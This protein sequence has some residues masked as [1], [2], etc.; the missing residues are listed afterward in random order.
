MITYTFEAR[1]DMSCEFYLYHVRVN[2]LNQAIR[3]AKEFLDLGYQ[4]I[5]V[6]TR[7]EKLAYKTKNAFTSSLAGH[8]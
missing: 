8:H 3:K 6:Y 7:S 4:D 5:K 1:E 2:T